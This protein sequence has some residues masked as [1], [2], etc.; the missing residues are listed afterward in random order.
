MHIV[1][2]RADIPVG[3]ERKTDLSYHTFSVRADGRMF[4]T[5]PVWDEDD[6]EELILSGHAEGVQLTFL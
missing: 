4:Y 5:W 3:R 1:A 6:R 2:C